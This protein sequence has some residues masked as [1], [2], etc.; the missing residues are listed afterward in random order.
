MYDRTKEPMEAS[1]YRADERFRG[2]LAWE[3]HD[4]QDYDPGKGMRGLR[5]V[6]R[7]NILENDSPQWLQDPAA[8]YEAAGEMS[9][10]EQ[11]AAEYAL[12]YGEAAAFEE[13]DLGFEA[14]FIDPDLFALPIPGL[15]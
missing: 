12:E 13:A 4:Q 6:G 15:E 10:Y 1:L 2:P 5:A 3:A 8:N 11:A 14:D 7:E 9:V